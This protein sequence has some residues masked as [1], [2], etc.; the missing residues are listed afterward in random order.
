MQTTAWS[1]WGREIVSTNIQDNE[2]RTGLVIYWICKTFSHQS[3]ATWSCTSHVLI[4]VVASSLPYRA[5]AFI[6]SHLNKV[7]QSI[8]LFHLA[9]GTKEQP[10]NM[11]FKPEHP[12]LA[13]FYYWQFLP[14]ARYRSQPFLSPLHLTYMKYIN[15][16]ASLH[17]QIKR[18]EQGLTFIPRQWLH[19]FWRLCRTLPFI[20]TLKLEKREWL[21]KEALSLPL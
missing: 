7:L 8:L 19:A 21:A 18:L 4:I 10:W 13:A 5:A 3:L 12:H 9:R 15:F 16:I 17:V 11:R 20:F 1:S 6:K 2:H 14:I